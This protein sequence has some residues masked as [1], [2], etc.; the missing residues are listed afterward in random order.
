MKSRGGKG[1]EHEMKDS[2]LNLGRRF[3]ASIMKGIEEIP[4]SDGMLLMRGVT[5]L[6]TGTVV[7]SIVI[8][9]VERLFWEE[10]LK[11][12]MTPDIRCRVCAVGTPGTGKTTSTLFLIRTLF[13]NKHTV[14]Y[15][16][17]G[18]S[19]FYVFKWRPYTGYD[20]NV[21]TQ[22]HSLWDV[23]S[24]SDPSTFYIV[25]PGNSG[26]NCLPHTSFAA[27]TIIVSTCEVSDYWGGSELTKQRGNVTGMF[28]IF[29]MWDLEELLMARPYLQETVLTD[30]DV[31]ARFRQVGGLPRYVFSRKR[32]LLSTLQNQKYAIASLTAK[33]AELI[34]NGDMDAVGS[35][36]DGRC[37]SEIIGYAK[38]YKDGEITFETRN[39]EFISQFVAAKVVEELIP[40]LRSHAPG[41]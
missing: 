4:K 23:E 15:R 27:R 38:T 14:V 39:V 21:Y 35:F 7:D 24:L 20:V 11:Q 29:P 8:R 41:R 19:Y 2:V 26:K 31:E 5:N 9:G 33:E 1:Q 37:K 28:R 30:E 3:V 32:Y 22:E 6:Q 34:V 16:F 13:E 40:D 10:C 25:D 18:A 17:P 12:V 36:V